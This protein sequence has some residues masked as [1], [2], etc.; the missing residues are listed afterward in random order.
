MSVIQNVIF[1]LDSR[2]RNGGG[3]IN[4]ATYNMIPAGGLTAGTYEMLSYHSQNQFYNVELGVNDQIHWDENGTANVTAVI[5]PGF[6]SAATLATE[7]DAVMTAASVAADAN[8][9]V[10]TYN[11]VTGKYSTTDG[12]GSAFGF[13][14][15][16]ASATESNLAN[17]LMGYSLVDNAALNTQVSDR[18]VTLTLHSMLVI[19][20]SEDSQQNVTLLSGSEHSLIVPLN[21]N[22]Q[23]EIDS[24]KQQV[25]SQQVVFGSSLNSINVQLFDETGVAPVN[26]TEYELTLRKIF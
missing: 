24:L 13:D 18:Q 8:T 17:E 11:A 23:A 15:L 5:A 2:Q 26:S 6:Y 19:D 25:F 22:Y 4:N 16:A 10:T 3:S 20:I 21:Q 9:Y 1:V 14:W 7:I 12:A